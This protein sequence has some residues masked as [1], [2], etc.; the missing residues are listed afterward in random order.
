MKDSKRQAVIDYYTK[1]STLASLYVEQEARKILVE[2]PEL[3]EFIMAMGFWYFTWKVGATDQNGIVREDYMSHV[4]L[5]GDVK[6]I[7]DSDLAEF[8]A[9]WDDILKI[10]GEPMR[11]TAK[12]KL[13]K[14]W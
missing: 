8:M 14:D 1:A 10:T 5:D 3:N 6:F 11:F 12:G 2:H 7:D 13:R 4:I 9:E